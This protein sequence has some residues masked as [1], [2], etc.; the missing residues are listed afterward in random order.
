MGSARRRA[1]GA[2]SITFVSLS[3]H[4]SSSLCLKK[5]WKKKALM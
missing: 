4:I 2:R 1:A 5:S 3:L